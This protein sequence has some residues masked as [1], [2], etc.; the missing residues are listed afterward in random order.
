MRPTDWYFSH[1]KSGIPRNVEQL[2]IESPSLDILQ[3]KNCGGSLPGKRLEAALRV[4]EVKSQNAPQ[5]QVEYSPE[6]LTSQWLTLGL[7]FGL[8]PARADRYI[9]PG[10]DSLKQPTCLANGRGQVGITEKQHLTLRVEHPVSY[11]VPLAS[12]AGI[13]K[14]AD[15]CMFLGTLAHNFGSRVRRAVVYYHDFQ[16]PVLLPCAGKN[17]LHRV[18][19]ARTLVVRRDYDAILERF[20]MP[21]TD[22][23]I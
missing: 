8:Q 7:E 14:Q 20:Q 16:F 3:G 21:I 6:K 10:Y 11:A 13:F 23:M 2:R 1:A 12:I 18:A 19:N 22:L 5:Q 9:R 17:F 15:L 4:F